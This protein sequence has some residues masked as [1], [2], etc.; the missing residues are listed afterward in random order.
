MAGW[1]RVFV[2]SMAAL[3]ATSPLYAQV[4]LATPGPA[5]TAFSWTGT[6]ANAAAG[7]TLIR[8]DIN[9]DVNRP[10]LLVGAPGSG[11][12]GQGQVFIDFM[13]PS[14]TGAVSLSSTDVIF[15][16]ESTGDR[17]GASVSAGF[18]ARSRDVVVGAPAASGGKGAVYLFPGP[19]FGGGETRSASTDRLLKVIGAPGDQLGASVVATDIDGDGFRDIVMAAP[20]SG[21][22]YILFG[23]AGLGGTV[24][25]SLRPPY[26]VAISTGAP[27]M[28]TLASADFD[29]DGRFKDLAIGIPGANS[30][31]GAVFFVLGRAPASFPPSFPGAPVGL[32]T[33]ASGYALGVRAG[34]H[35]GYAL[36]AADFD[37]D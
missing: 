14:H 30:G 16:G 3:G 8:V 4:T 27:G 24:D 10:D 28:L 17:F 35:A 23:G 19:F 7:T 26:V 22:V 6:R 34:D 20:G 5:G 21:N 15:T 11:P 32:L 13:G 9:G 37:G 31:A 12:A 1:V 2:F 33:V 29:V 18:I 25:L 36:Q